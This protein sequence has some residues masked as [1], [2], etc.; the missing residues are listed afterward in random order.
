VDEHR[1]PLGWAP[2][3]GDPNRRLLPIGHTFRLDRDSMRAALDA[4][5]LSPVGIAVGVDADAAV[6]G[7]ADQAE[8]SATIRALNDEEGA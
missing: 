6:V 7:V 5:V 1:R 2:P 4:A 8:I 3:D